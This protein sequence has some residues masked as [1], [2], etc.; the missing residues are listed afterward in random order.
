M[1]ISS[2]KIIYIAGILMLAA[3]FSWQWTK[4]EQLIQTKSH[5]IP[6]APEA[7]VTAVAETISIIL[8]HNLLE[9]ARGQVHA[10]DKEKAQIK[11]KNSQW[12]LLATVISEHDDPIA[13]IEVNKE[14]KRIHQG[15]TLPD[16]AYLERIL[17]E[18]C[19]V[20][21]KEEKSFV[22]LFGKQ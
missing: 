12:K 16:G 19:I 7:P 6:Q 17:E 14:K 13:I 11:Q 22:Y 2:E 20:K 21:T 8:A 4:S 18:G 9:E 3:Y 5:A 15:D 10:S 1:T